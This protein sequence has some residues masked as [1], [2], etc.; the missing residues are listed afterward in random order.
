M[1]DWTTKGRSEKIARLFDLT[2]LYW[3]MR[4]D[5]EGFVA[6]YGLKKL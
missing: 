6:I 1:T 4:S 2:I 5:R 3:I